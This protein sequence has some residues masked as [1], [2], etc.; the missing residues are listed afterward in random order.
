MEIFIILSALFIIL[1]YTIAKSCKGGP[2]KNEIQHLYSATK[3]ARCET[4]VDNGVIKK[5]YCDE[6]I[7]VMWTLSLSYFNY[8]LKN[9][10]N[11][12]II[13]HKASAS[14]INRPK[15]EQKL[16]LTRASVYETENNRTPTV[17][18]PNGEI[19]DSMASPFPPSISDPEI[20]NYALNNV[21]IHAE[22]SIIANNTLIDYE[23]S[24]TMKDLQYSKASTLQDN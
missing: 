7:T 19:K 22:M 12:E 15:G 18:P 23:F 4:F 11:R 9:K 8:A 14:S 6:Y 10:A 16:Y 24:F 21:K 2:V 3:S 17:I 13:L 20:F 1:L 5:I